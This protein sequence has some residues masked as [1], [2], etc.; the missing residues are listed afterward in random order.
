M[1]LWILS[2]TQGS[3]ASSIVGWGSVSALNVLCYWHSSHWS[4]PRFPRL[5][6]VIRGP[7]YHLVQGVSGKVVGYFLRTLD[8]ESVS[9]GLRN[10]RFLK[11]ESS[12]RRVQ[13][14]DI[15]LPLSYV[16]GRGKKRELYRSQVFISIDRSYDSLQLATLLV[17]CFHFLY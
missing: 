12:S 14:H 15:L 17:C 13:P 5:V 6:I 1:D 9:S 2:V 3:S 7:E 11:V 16:R 10:Y 4:F 8:A